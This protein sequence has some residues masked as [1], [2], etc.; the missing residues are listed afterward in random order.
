MNSKYPNQLSTLNP[1]RGLLVL[2]AL[3]VFGGFL[4]RQLAAFSGQSALVWPPAGIALAGILVL[5]FRCWPGVLFGSL[6]FL[7]VQGGPPGFFMLATAAGNTVGAI[8]CAFLLQRLAKFKNS[9]ERTRDA[10]AFV[11]LAG[12][13]GAAINALFNLA[14]LWY[15]HKVLSTALNSTF[16]DWCLSNA[17]ALLVVTPFLIVWFAP[18]SVRLS[19]WRGVEAGVCAAGLICGTLVAFDTGFVHRLPEYPLAYLPCPFL[20]WG[21]LRFGARGAATGTLLM[22]GLAVYSLRA[23]HGPFLTGDP[24]GN[25]R[26]VGG[27]LAIVAAA[28]LL[29]AAAAGERRRMFLEALDNENRLRLLLADQ[30]DL[31][32]R[33][34]PNGRLTF[35]NPA[36]CEFYGQTEEQ[37][38]G[39]DFFQKLAPAEAAALR[40]KLAGLA[41]D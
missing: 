31:I 8:V 24:A 39:A 12:V 10:L 14:G 18:S 34:Q 22:A 6:A 27:C 20:A 13:L 32:C 3:Y 16:F 19:F 40:G 36:Y 28:N 4:C 1:L 35:V 23:G 26:L 9:L 33:F 15:D 17:L 29:L 11:L 5:G 37:L 30:L 7:I 2:T 21:A 38:L 41:S 25:L